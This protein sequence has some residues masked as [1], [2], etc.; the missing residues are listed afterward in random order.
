[1]L[2]RIKLWSENVLYNFNTEIAHPLGSLSQHTDGYIFGVTRNG[3]IGNGN[4]F[5]YNPL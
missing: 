3:G 5:K 2:A 1:M 4:V